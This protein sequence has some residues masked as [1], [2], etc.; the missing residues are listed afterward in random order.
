MPDGT[1]FAGYNLF[2]YCG[3]NPINRIDPTGST[4]E[5]EV[6]TFEDFQHGGLLFV[7]L[8]FLTTTAYAS[9]EQK[10]R[11]TINASFANSEFRSYRTDR[12]NHH[13]VA[14][15]AKNAEY[16]REV[17]TSVGISVNSPENL[18]LI[19][20][21]LHRRLHTDLYYGWANSVVIAAYRN[22]GS[23]K[24]EQKKAVLGALGIIRG[25]VKTLDLISPF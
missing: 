7:S 6:Y 23:D 21:G 9:K 20:T 12:E 3:D 5:D 10:L 13:L 24:A 17:L 15:G 4:P 1:D 18:L 2:T 22:A 11:T 8:A 25:V 14:K 19:K 16:A